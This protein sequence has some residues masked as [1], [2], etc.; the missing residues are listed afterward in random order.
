GATPYATVSSRISQH[1][2]R[3]F[4]HSPPRPPILGR[5]AHEKHTRKYFYYIASALEQDDFQRKVRAGIIPL[6]LVSSGG[7]GSADGPRKARPAKKPRCIVPAI[8]VES[9]LS[10]A[11][12]PRRAA[13]A[14]PAQPSPRVAARVAARS[15]L[16]GGTDQSRRNT[17]PTVSLRPR[18]TSFDGASGGS[19]SDSESNPYARKR[20]RSVRSAVAHAYPRRLSRRQLAGDGRSNGGDESDGSGS[21]DSSSGHGG[22]SSNSAPGLYTHSAPRAR[23]S[24]SHGNTHPGTPGPSSS[25]V[26]RPGSAGKWRPA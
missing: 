10:P 25:P 22:Q 16:L 4:D 19:S 14:D 18:R 21:A 8:A 1:F 2:K 11:P 5:V 3:I 20:F 24:A 9:D 13:S 23:R 12:R 6:Q 26:R 7:S 15:M 17:A